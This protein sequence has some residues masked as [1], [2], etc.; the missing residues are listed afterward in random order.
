MFRN[1]V[2]PII[3]SVWLPIKERFL[4]INP[5]GKLMMHSCGSIRPL[6]SDFIEMGADILD[7]IQ[8]G[9]KDMNG[10]LLKREFGDRLSFHGGIDTQHVM[11]TGSLEAVELE[12]KRRIE[13]LAPGG[14]YILNP[15]HDVVSEVLPDQLLRMVQVGKTYGRYPI[16]R[17]FSDEELLAL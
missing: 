7:P 10:L 3:A 9:A 15:S 11:S 12:T 16:R 14:G 8:P 6:I 4:N 17:G 2:K 1:L 5:E 13:M